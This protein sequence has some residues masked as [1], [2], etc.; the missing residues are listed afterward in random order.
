[1]SSTGLNK[2]I[3]QACISD[4]FQAGLMNGHRAELL[5]GFDLDP[6]EA[7]AL[8]AIHAES[9]ADFAAVVEAMLQQ[10]ENHPVRADSPFIAAVRWPSTASMGVYFRHQR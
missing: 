10:R 1:M 2:L 8:L 3:G 4:S 6:E 5:R 9:F 7:R